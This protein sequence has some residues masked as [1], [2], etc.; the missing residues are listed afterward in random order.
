MTLPLYPLDAF[1]YEAG[2]VAGTLI[3][4][5][6]GFVLERSGFGRAPV[7]AAQFYFV[8]TRVLKVMFTSIVTALLGTTILAGAG[9]LD[10]A[11]LTVP[12]TFLWAQIAGGLLLGVGFI[13][14]GYCPGTAV[15]SAGSG[16]VDGWMT[17]L[18]VMAGSLLYGA[19][20]PWLADIEA[21]GAMGVVRL[22]DL[23]GVPQALL[24]AG[25]A[26][27]A[28]GMFF[29]G[30]ALERIFARS[31]GADGPP[32]S[33]VTRNR[34]FVGLGIAVLGGIATLGMPKGEDARPPAR[35]FAAIDSL[36]LARVLVERPES[37]YLVDLR[38][39]AE[40][41]AQRIPGAVCLPADDPS[42]GF[43]AD[44]PA[45]RELVLYAATDLRAVPAAASRFTGKVSVL[46]GGFAAFERLIL[47]APMPPADATPE[48]IA[49]F[50]LIT[51]LH[52]RFTGATVPVVPPPTVQPVKARPAGAKKGGGC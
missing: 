6:F 1:G 48:S 33:T 18:G 52:A 5:A 44:L 28:I 9:V 26:M 15:V 32:L 37:V 2:L 14:S 50:R 12:E 13:V 35:S 42:G 20:H 47:V 46:A 16:N 24:A 7:L 27:M 34:V 21:A 4:F 25:V 22:P 49:R 11:L 19:F 3:G 23:L 17:I 45:T 51:A 40:C 39:P 31:R 43:F 10:V 8:D 30:E 36:D 38:A 41:A 29:G